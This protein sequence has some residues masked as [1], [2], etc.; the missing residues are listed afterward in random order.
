MLLQWVISRKQLEIPGIYIYIL[1]AI[2]C[3]NI[4]KVNQ[5][6]SYLANEVGICTPKNAFDYSLYEI[7]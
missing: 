2:L 6:R 1:N 7:D 3:E 4:I 5:T